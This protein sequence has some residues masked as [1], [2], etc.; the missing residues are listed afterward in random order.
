MD[1]DGLTALI[2]EGPDD[3][4]AAAVRAFDGDINGFGVGGMTP[5]MLAVKTGRLRTIAALADAG[6]DP[7]CNH[8]NACAL[9]VAAGLPN[10]SL[11]VGGGAVAAVCSPACV[12]ACACACVRVR[13]CICVYACVKVVPACAGARRCCPRSRTSTIVALVLRGADVDVRDMFLETPADMATR[14]GLHRCAA[15]LRRAV[16]WRPRASC[17][18]WANVT[19]SLAPSFLTHACTHAH[20]LPHSSRFLPFL[21]D[22]RTLHSCTHQEWLYPL[23]RRSW[24][25]R[26]Y[27]ICGSVA[28]LQGTAT[29][30]AE[31]VRLRRFWTRRRVWFAPGAASTVSCSRR[32]EAPQRRCIRAAEP[33]AAAHLA[34]AIRGA[35]RR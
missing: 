21:P 10:G 31:G 13:V 3:A 12:C 6:A 25:V 24:C 20:A 18:A 15:L 7:N 32:H 2:R 11:Q 28:E 34:P 35:T 4:A 30:V 14:L 5:L 22:S 33:A 9:F 29:P 23:D 16:S 17:S 27:P 26:F 1:V 8:G 19:P